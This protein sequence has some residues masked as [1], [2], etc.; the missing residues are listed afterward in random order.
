MQ[1]SMQSTDGKQ[2][3]EGGEGGWEGREGEKG[4]EGGRGGWEGRE[5]GE[6]GWEGEKG[7]EVRVMQKTMA[8]HTCNKGWDKVGSRGTVLSNTPNVLA[9]TS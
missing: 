5:G 2:R 9:I 6:G 3:R 7:G 4:G 8:W 1:S